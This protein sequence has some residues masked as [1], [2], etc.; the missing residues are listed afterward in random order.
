MSDALESFEATEPIPEL[1]V[2]VG[3]W[4]SVELGSRLSVCVVKA[5]GPE[6][7]QVLRTYQLRKGREHLRLVR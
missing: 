7:L 4:V 3:D 1:G 2:A 6:A 5:K